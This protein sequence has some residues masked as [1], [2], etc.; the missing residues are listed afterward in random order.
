MP[1]GAGIAIEN[2]P[3]IQE[4]MTIQDV[5]SILGVGPG[6]FSGA[7]KQW[8]IDLTKKTMGTWNDKP[9]SHI[10]FGEEVTIGIWLDEAGSVAH[11]S[12]LAHAFQGKRFFD[13]VKRWLGL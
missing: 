1:S 4:G 10:W 8:W 11:K 7:G 6:D 9:P 3:K 13:T 2:Y 5:Q 12:Y